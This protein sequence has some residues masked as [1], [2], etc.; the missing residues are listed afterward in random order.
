VAVW[1]KGF[2][3]AGY[4]AAII[5]KDACG[6]WIKLADYGKTTSQ[7]GWE[8]DHI[9]PESL[10]GSDVISNLQPLQWQNNR[11]KGNSTVLACPIKAAS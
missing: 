6:A 10:G 7:W 5:R 11:A 1:T 3:V 8:I 2:I 9:Y 4:D